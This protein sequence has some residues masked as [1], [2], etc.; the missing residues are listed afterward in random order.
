M[1]S[2]PD[3]PTLPAR[4]PAG[5]KGTF[6]TVAI[7]G[8]SARA[9]TRMIGAPAL[10]ATAAL[11][12]G[13]G[14]ARLIMPA[15]I[16]DAALTIAPCAT[17]RAI[18][19][20]TEGNI[21]PHEAAAVIDAVI[22]DCTCLAI[23]PGLGR[24]EGPRAAV[25]RAVQQQ[26][27][28]VVVD[29]DALNCLSEVPQLT[30]D[31]RAA[32]VFTPHPGEFRRLTR[33]MGIKD[34]L[35]LDASRERGA[36]QLAQRLGCIIVLKGAGTVVSDGARTW[37]NT[38]GHPC[39]ATGGSGDVLTGVIASL[40]AQFVASAPAVTQPGSLPRPPGRPLDLFDAARVAVSIH[41]RAGES[42]ATRSGASG[43][44]LATDLL[45]ELPLAVERMRQP[46]AP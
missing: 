17:G 46:G 31:L 12:A 29:A 16:L 18:P 35:G 32:A 6:G 37:T 8:G 4:D 25:L 15:P 33:A 44:M 34:D 20:D 11:R 10:A 36:E 19:T 23:G 28:P 45:D 1:P 42:W 2:P 41:G 30:R 3:L 38:T 39:L 7:V 43:G 13:C 22:R 27:V 14:L 26:N 5:H 9:D 24:G 40:L 21:I